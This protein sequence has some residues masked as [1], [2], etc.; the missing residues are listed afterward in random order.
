M[1]VILKFLLEAWAIIALIIGILCAFFG[2][3]LWAAFPI[4]CAI[5][6]AYSASLIDEI[7]D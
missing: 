3:P 6:C 7:L 5:A 1:A 4:V 2:A